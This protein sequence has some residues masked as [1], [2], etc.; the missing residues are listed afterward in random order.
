MRTL[1]TA[2]LLRHTPDGE[3]VPDHAVLVDGDRVQAVGP[4]AELIEAYAGVRVRRW[5]GTLGPGRRTTLRCR[6]RPPH[7]SGCTRCCARG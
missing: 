7:A 1:H 3:P 6:R 2:P 5:P 4:L